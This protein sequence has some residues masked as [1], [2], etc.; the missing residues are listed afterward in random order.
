MTTV[1]SCIRE[2]SCIV[3]SMGVDGNCPLDASYISYCV[4]RRRHLFHFYTGLLDLLV[5][6]VVASR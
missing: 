2:S 6:L 4:Y 1:R 3:L 5:S